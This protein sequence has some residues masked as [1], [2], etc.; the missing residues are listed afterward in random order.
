MVYILEAIDYPS[1]YIEVEANGEIKTHSPRFFAKS[2]S[3]IVRGLFKLTQVA[4]RAGRRE[5]HGVVLVHAFKGTGQ[6]EVELVVSQ[7]RPTQPDY[8]Q[9]G[10]WTHRMRQGI[11][12]GELLARCHFTN[13]QA[14]AIL[15]PAAM[16]AHTA[17]AQSQSARVPK[18]TPTQAKFAPAA[19]INIL[20]SLQ[21]HMEQDP[22]L[23]TKYEDDAGWNKATQGEWAW[24]GDQRNQKQGRVIIREKEVVA[25]VTEDAIRL[26][27]QA[28]ADAHP[29]KPLTLNLTVNGSAGNIKAFAEDYIAKQG[30][31]ITINHPQ[32]KQ[33]VPA[34]AD[35]NVANAAN[36]RAHMPT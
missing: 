1:C 4:T 5:E 26:A 24:Q 18:P 17:A 32:R 2:G 34:V 27:L 31:L 20:A 33:P 9:S 28:L 36:I 13:E 7:P 12:G 11:D 25:S 29:G 21:Q 35:E 22:A 19:P 6:Q 3:G 14:E 10:A 30:W 23:Q 16:P 15:S 8:N